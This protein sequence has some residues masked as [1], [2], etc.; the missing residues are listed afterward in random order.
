MWDKYSILEWKLNFFDTTGLPDTTG[1][2]HT[3]TDE[4]DYKTYSNMP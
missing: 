4:R 3:S 2:Q 1:I